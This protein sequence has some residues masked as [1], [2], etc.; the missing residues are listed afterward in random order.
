MLHNLYNI[1]C[2]C[3]LCH[4][5]RILSTPY[6]QSFQNRKN[7]KYRVIHKS[8]RDFRLLLYS[9]Q[10]CHV[11]GEHVNKGR[12]TPTFCP[13]LQVLNMST[14]GDAANAKFGNFGKFQDTKLFLISC[15]RH[16]SSQ[17]PPSGETCK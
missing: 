6:K 13:T 5:K 10:D 14:L 2:L 1:E 15:P 3:Y 9:N 8:R 12:D 4:S 17:L 11:E 7:L 16:Y